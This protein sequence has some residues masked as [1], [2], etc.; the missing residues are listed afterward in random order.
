[1]KINIKV[2]FNFQGYLINCTLRYHRL[3]GWSWISNLTEWFCCIVWHLI[4]EI[5]TI[6][7]IFTLFLRLNAFSK[8]LFHHPP[9]LRTSYY[10]MISKWNKRASAWPTSRVIPKSDCGI[11]YS[12]NLTWY[13][14]KKLSAFV[15]RRLRRRCWVAL[16]P[17]VWFFNSYLCIFIGVLPK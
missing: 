4:L 13:L 17:T 15:C 1:M 11:R 5:Y 16:N 2:M 9:L 6:G 14:L 10:T 12:D 3:C 8:P 7:N